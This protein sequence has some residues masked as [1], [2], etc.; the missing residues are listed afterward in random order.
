MKRVYYIITLAALVAVFSCEDFM[1]VHQDFIEGGEIIYSPKTDSMSFI[2]GEHRILFRC[3]LYNSPNVQSVDLYW[4]NKTDSL[5]TPVS[6]S[7]GRDSIDIMLA[8]LE[9]KS[10]T[11]N[12]RTTDRFGHK[13]LWTTSFGNAYGDN[14]RATLTDRRINEVSLEEKDGAPQGK[15]TFFSAAVLQVRNEVRYVK[16]DGSKDVVALSPDRSEIY[17]IDAK[18]GSSFETRSFYI[19]EE[20]SVDTFATQWHVN[21]VAFPL[22][23]MFDRT[24]WTVVAV[25]DETASDGGG[26]HAVID[27]NT[28]T[29]WHSQ[30]DGGNA[31]LPHWLIIDLGAEISTADVVRFDLY[32]RSNNTDTKTVEIYFGNSSDP[33]G[34]WTKVAETVVNA[35]K[36]EVTP[37]DRT[38]SGRYLKLVLPDS[39]RSPF[40]NLAEVYMYGGGRE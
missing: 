5:I 14:Y 27:G 40:T 10:Y 6:P 39:N 25:S 12:V 18:P 1:D 13:S 38:T 3:W 15:V 24:K 19:P 30:W 21:E 17:C 26:M 23:Y 20:E 8:G 11:F 33:D 2:A 22:I 32:R 29:Y 31:P 28:G 9:E 7:M 4:N 34:I 35:N 16:S 36:M 37:S